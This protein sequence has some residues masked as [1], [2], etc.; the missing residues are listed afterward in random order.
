M[1]YLRDSGSNTHSKG[2]M[3]GKRTTKEMVAKRCTKKK[4]GLENALLKRWWLKGALKR[5]QG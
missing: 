4:A 1:H 2:D 3:V 5:R